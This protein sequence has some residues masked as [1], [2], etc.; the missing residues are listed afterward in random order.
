MSI[1]TVMLQSTEPVKVARQYLK[2]RFPAETQTIWTIGNKTWVWYGDKWTCWDHATLTA[3]L[4]VWL[5]DAKIELA[6][7]ERKRFVVYPKKVDDIQLCLA[8]ITRLDRGNPPLWMGGGPGWD[9]RWCVAF[10]DVVVHVKEDGTVETAERTPNW[11]DNV[12]LPCTWEKARETAT[13]TWD[14]C[15]DQWSAGDANWKLR[16]MRWVGYCMVGYREYAKWLH[17]FGKSRSGKTTYTEV[18]HWLVGTNASIERTMKTLARKYGTHGI[19][20]AR[21]LVVS[22]VTQLERGDG[23]ILEGILKQIL[24]RNEVEAEQKYRDAVYQKSNAAPMLVGN[25]MVLLPDSNKGLTSKM[26]ML[27][28][29]GSYL[30]REDWELADKLREELP[31]IAYKAV[32]A[33][34]E[35][36]V[37]PHA[38]KWPVPAKEAALVARLRSKT[39]IGHAFLEGR[40]LQSG[41][42]FVPFRTL[43]AEWG[44]YQNELGERLPM[45]RRHLF[46]WIEDASGWDVF[47]G[48]HGGNRGFWGM[49]FR[50]DQEAAH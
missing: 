25:E 36:R 33:L 44:R 14:R 46:D 12:V 15:M 31:G 35:L 41:K 49:G 2:E 9:P 20:E 3:D 38:E 10:E 45:T 22:E 4:L 7:G 29:A 21:T 43:W 24:G 11:V 1:A 32:Q 28:F 18:I 17:P 37:A 27:P 40:F 23:E 39:H 26:L 48:E 16:A 6:N 50:K 47:R 19:H 8:A 42:S 13:P 30:G 34:G 5:E